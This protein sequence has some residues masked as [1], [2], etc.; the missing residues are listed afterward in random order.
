MFQW[1]PA[2]L[3]NF[4]ADSG[5]PAGARAAGF[6][7]WSGTQHRMLPRSVTFL[8][9]F[10]LLFLGVCAWEMARGGLGRPA[11]TTAAFLAMIGLLAA[12]FFRP[13]RW[14]PDRATAVKHLFLFQ[15]LFDVCLIAAVAWVAGRIWAAA[16]PQ[17]SRKNRNSVSGESK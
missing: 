2:R 8:G 12:A 4:T 15:V 11:G 9:I 10:G 3:G 6:V 17:S 5:Q 14:C 16:F 7:H 1:R 13:V